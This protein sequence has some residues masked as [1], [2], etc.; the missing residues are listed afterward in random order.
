[1]D[2]GTTGLHGGVRVTK[3]DIRVEAYGTLDELNC[4]IGVVRSLLA[5][6]DRSALDD[7]LF[8]I[9]GNLMPVMSIVA[10]PSDQR[11]GNPNLLPADLVE[12]AEHKIDAFTAEAGESECFLLPGGTPVAAQLQLAR[13][14]CRR[15]ERRLW[16][17][18]RQDP[19]PTE[20]LRYVNRLS[21]LFFIM[22]R[23][24]NVRQGLPEERWKSFTYKRRAK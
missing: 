4:Q 20:I 1:G 14:V 9:Q 2:E 16:T 6:D 11:D 15:A 12:D 17:L 3:D 8:G 22:A 5:G 23:W 10:T 19:V 13:A 7:V 24:E 18:N 21:D